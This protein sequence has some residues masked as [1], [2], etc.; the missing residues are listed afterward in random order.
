MWRSLVAW[1]M[2]FKEVIADHSGSNDHQR[3]Q[4]A[5][6]KAAFFL[7]LNGLRKEGGGC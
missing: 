1:S 6:G 2:D 3:N 4:P 5:G 7:G